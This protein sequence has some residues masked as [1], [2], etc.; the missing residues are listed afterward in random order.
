MPAVTIRTKNVSRGE[1]RRLLKTLAEKLETDQSLQ[2]IIAELAAYESKYG[3]ST[4]EFYPQFIAGKLGDSSEFMLWASL[5]EA[6]VE[7]TQPHLIAQT[8]A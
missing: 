3:M 5:Y 6:Y 8:A 4:L 1:A 2:E 7:L